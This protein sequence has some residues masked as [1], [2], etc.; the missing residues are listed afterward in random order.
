MIFNSE[1]LSLLIIDIGVIIQ[2]QTNEIFHKDTQNLNNLILCI[3][4]HILIS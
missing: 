3:L 1:N 2:L 4:K